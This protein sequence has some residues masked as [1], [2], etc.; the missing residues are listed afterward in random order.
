[1]LLRFWLS[2]IFCTHTIILA[3][4]QPSVARQWNEALLQAIREDWSRPTIHARNL[5]HSSIAMYDSWAVY[6]GGDTYFLGKSVGGFAVSFEGIDAPLDLD[7]ARDETLSYAVYRLM[8]HRFKKSPGARI[9]LRRFRDLFES[10]GY[11]PS[12]RS[13][14]YHKGS[15]AALGNYLGQKLIEF[16]LQDGSN[17]RRKYTNKFYRPVNPALVPAGPG[18]PRIQDANRW[19]SLSLEAFVDQSGN[20]LPADDIPHLSA[21][22]GKVT[23]FSLTEKDRIINQRDGNQ[24]WIYH[25]PGPPPYIDPP[26]NSSSDDYKWNFMLVS[27]WSSQLDPE[28]GVIW[29]ISPATIGKNISFPQNTEELKTFYK[30]YEG[31]DAATGHQLNPATGEPYVPQLVPRGDY[32]RVLAEFWADGPD[33]ETPP[34]HWFAILNYVGDHPLFQKKYRGG[35]QCMMRQWRPGVLKDGTIISVQYRRCDL[36]RMWVNAV[37]G[38]KPVIR[39]TEF[40]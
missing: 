8:M 5:W 34:G 32:T 31:G 39:I 19:Q 22:W 28:D 38:I 15:P 35:E 27:I 36:W 2:L 10:Q 7:Q 30:L 17:E 14:N 1:M 20:A 40:P 16:G 29:D 13:A 21:E 11:D 24:Y 6:G 3:V 33:S 26:G 37:T 9:S 4:G 18:N 12:Y 23:P 25:D